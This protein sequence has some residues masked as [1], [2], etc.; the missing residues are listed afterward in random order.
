MNTLR[1]VACLLLLNFTFQSCNQEN[2]FD[3]VKSTGPRVTEERTVAAF[4]TIVLEDNID[5]YL[6]TRVASNATIEAGKNLIP[7][8]DFS[9]KG[10]TLVISNKNSCEWVRSYKYPVSVTIGIPAES[11]AL[12]H[13]GYGK[14]TN[15]GSLPLS[16]LSVLSLDAGGD[17]ELTIRSNSLTIYS[18]SHALINIAGQVTTSYIWINKGIGRIHAENLQAQ[19]CKVQQEGSNEIRVFPIQKLNVEILQSGNVAYYHQP[20]EL[21]S[22]IRGTGRLIKR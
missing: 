22:R 10:D 8:I 21:T 18:N 1:L 17:I 12:V 15:A 7:K 5:L 13:Q 9:Y 14:I 16:D 19:Y 2:A 11:L 6:D 4:H 20:A 3:C